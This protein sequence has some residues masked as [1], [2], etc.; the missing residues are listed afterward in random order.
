MSKPFFQVSG[1]APWKWWLLGSEVFAVIVLFV[2]QAP[3]VLGFA[4]GWFM[5]A[6]TVFVWDALRE[7]AR[8]LRD[9]DRLKQ[10]ERQ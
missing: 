6:S 2:A 5:M 4:W 10:G 9:E 7:H 3:Y 8:G 1:V